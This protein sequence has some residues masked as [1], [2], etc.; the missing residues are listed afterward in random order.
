MV[1]EAGARAVK[2][3]L[4]T[5]DEALRTEWRPVLEAGIAV[6]RSYNGVMPWSGWLRQ[7]D[8]AQ[9]PPNRQPIQ[10]PPTIPQV[11]ANQT[12]NTFAPPRAEYQPPASHHR[13]AN[14]SSRPANAL[15]RFTRLAW[16]TNV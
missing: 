11:R 1:L 2:V 9:Q 5:S 13:S 10:T 16:M 6:R 14:P 15:P 4:D 7:L 12:A 3:P 8:E